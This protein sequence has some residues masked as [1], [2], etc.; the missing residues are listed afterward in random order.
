MRVPF[1][2]P[3]NVSKRNADRLSGNVT[4]DCYM[5]NGGGKSME[6]TVSVTLPW[7]YERWY[8]RPESN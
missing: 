8:R 2:H 5:E 1:R 4:V 6:V 3:S 7:F